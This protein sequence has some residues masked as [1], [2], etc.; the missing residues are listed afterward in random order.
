V[1]SP[2]SDAGLT[3]TEIRWLAAQAGIALASKPASPCLSSRVMTGIEI[4]PARLRDV[5]DL[6]EILRRGGAT[7]V[8]VRVCREQGASLFLRIEAEPEAMGRVLAC[9]EELQAAA[10]ARGYRWVT[11]DLGGYRMGG[12]VS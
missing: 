11:L 3:K 8:R 2:L 7:V 12:G 6:E 10:A 1:L 9:R 4:T 5:A